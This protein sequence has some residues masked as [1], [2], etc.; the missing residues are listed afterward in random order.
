MSH[1]VILTGAGISAES[2]LGTFREKDG[3]WTKYDLNEVATPEGFAR[4][5]DLVHAFY[6]ARRANCRN[7]QPNAAHAALARL[8]KE[9]GG[10][11][12]IVTQNVDDLHERAGAT[13]VIHMHGTL[14]GALC[15]ACDHRWTAPLAMS[16]DD[17]CPTCK[18]MATRPDIVWFG[19]MPYHMDEIYHHLT[20]ADLFVAIGTS[21]NV[22]PAAGFAAEAQSAGVE[23]IELNLEPSATA[24]S[25]DTA[26]F[27]PATR[28]VPLWVAEILDER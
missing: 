28:I 23:T 13:D 10:R 4:N 7:A 17:P 15:A 1:I 21:G 20:G 11:V 12:T 3:L 18:E 5:P 26:R 22:Y 27:G 2:R 9:H 24:N 25:F 8:Q 16:T 19:E 14:S 6:N